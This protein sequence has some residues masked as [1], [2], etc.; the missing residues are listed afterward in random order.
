MLLDHISRII[1]IPMV[2]K[3]I[4]IPNG[5]KMHNVKIFYVCACGVAVSVCKNPRS[6]LSIAAA[7]CVRC[8]ENMKHTMAHDVRTVVATRSSSVAAA[9]IPPACAWRGRSTCALARCAQRK[10]ANLR[11]Y[12]WWC[13]VRRR[14]MHAVRCTIE[15]TQH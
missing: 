15:C 5:Y 7:M 12:T 8:V 11:Y 10:I 2:I 4:N 6:N 13:R 14:H 3:I 1:N 9:H